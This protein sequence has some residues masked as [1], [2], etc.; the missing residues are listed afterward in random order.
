M[1]DF[2]HNNDDQKGSVSMENGF[3]NGYLNM[4][5]TCISGSAV[6]MAWVII[7]IFQTDNVTQGRTTIAFFVP[8]TILGISIIV[9]NVMNVRR[10]YLRLKEL[11]SSM[12]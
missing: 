4:L 2:S 9:L 8:F 6:A 3:Y 12:D 7:L 5:R 11:L 1:E 10:A